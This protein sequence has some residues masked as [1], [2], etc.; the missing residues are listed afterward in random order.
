MV[1]TRWTIRPRS[2]SWTGRDDFLERSIDK[3]RALS[4]LRSFV[5][6]F[7]EETLTDITGQAASS[8]YAGIGHVGRGRYDRFK[9]ALSEARV[10]RNRLTVPRR[11]HC[12][13]SGSPRRK[14]E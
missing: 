10:R 2:I 7:R 4:S 9:P 5:G 6:L 13:T 12:Q 1:A 11:S 14:A 3:K 8:P